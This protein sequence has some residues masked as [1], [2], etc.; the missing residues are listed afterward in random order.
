MK[1][2]QTKVSKLRGTD[3]HEVYKKAFNYYNKVKGKTKRRP[4]IRS[5]YFNKDK[6]FLAIFWSHLKQKN[7][8]DRLRRI[9]YLP[10]AI[11]LIS[12]SRLE[13]ISKENPNKTTE[14]L[15]RFAGVTIDK[16]IFFVQIK[17]K[18]KTGKKYFISTYPLYDK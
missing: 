2:Y 7:W 6:I 3:Y 5:T 11:E 10:P 15:H 9:R 18:K 1:T 16:D 4:Y 17:E 8:R 13:P 14:V 12:N